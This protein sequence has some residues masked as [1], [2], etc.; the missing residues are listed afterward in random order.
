MNANHS[1]NPPGK[2]RIPPDVLA[3][4]QGA[5]L[6]DAEAARCASKSAW[7]K[8][9]KGP[10]E[11]LPAPAGE[12]EARIRHPKCFADA[13]PADGAPATVPISP[14][15]AAVAAGALAGIVPHEFVR[16]CD[17][18]RQIADLIA[19]SAAG[20]L[21]C[22]LE[23]SAWFAWGAAPGWRPVDT[24]ALQAAVTLAGRGNLGH[25]NIKGET[26]M[27]PATGG[28]AATAAG[29]L[30]ILAGLPGILTHAADWDADPALVGLPNGEIL[31]LTTGERR[32]PQREDRIRRRLGAMPATDAEYSRSR[33]AAVLNHCIPDQDAR[34]F[35][36]RRLGAALQNAEGLD[37]LIALNGPGGSGKGS[38]LAAI[39]AVFGEYESGVPTAEILTG[40]RRS[41]SAWKARLAGCRL[42]T[43]DDL[44]V[45]RD[46]DTAVIKELVGGRLNGVQHMGAEF[47]DLILHAPILTAGNAPPSVP[48]MDS[49][50]E[51]R[52]VPI[53]CGPPVT[54][55]DPAF[56]ESMRT[57]T[58]RGAA[59]RWLINGGV[60]YR[61]AGCAIP[62][63]AR[64]AAAEVG[65][66]SPIGEFTADWVSRHGAERRPIGEI[67]TAWQA[68]MQS[69]GRPPGGKNR[70]SGE[71]VAAG[72]ER[73]RVQGVRL[74]APPAPIGKLGAAS[75]A[76]AAT[77]Y[78][79]PRRSQNGDH[80]DRLGSGTEVRHLAA[81]AEP[82]DLPAGA[83]DGFEGAAPPLTGP[84]ENPD[85]PPPAPPAEPPA[86]R[87]GAA[88]VE[89]ESGDPD[90]IDAILAAAERLLGAPDMKAAAATQIRKMAGKDRYRLCGGPP[91]LELT[92]PPASLM[93]CA[94]C[95]VTYRKMAATT[96]AE[97]SARVDQHVGGKSIDEL[98]TAAQETAV[99]C[100]ERE[101]PDAMRD[102]PSAERLARAAKI[103][104]GIH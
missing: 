78:P 19:D 44:P 100:I 81:L 64:E 62:A 55:P 88:T 89:T 92:A 52:L 74:L 59:L 29:V 58:E 25:V 73:V 68:F 28:R 86:N 103:A 72:W 5:T 18:E 33:F 31:N 94:E 10:A 93:L 63:A 13:A 32:Q 7:A 56:R 6:T 69:S 30:R 38:I 8:D 41:H 35:L 90:R 54:N 36:A 82:D 71:L 101:F 39:R 84:A 48:G 16:L 3:W 87:K 4:L 102:V 79:M 85:S 80:D 22:I 57:V 49:G 70:L 45:G 26:S 40:G 9:G 42:L 46:L 12:D 95:A 53:Q 76:S 50:T 1:T 91:L 96:P 20:R 37:H 15:P 83:L 51:R 34:T 65:R 47:F 104:R 75:A 2:M 77:T 23:E 97:L 60:E 24:E 21:A 11:L 14:A 43:V 67:Y 98:W 17:S 66:D 99:A 27:R 61:A